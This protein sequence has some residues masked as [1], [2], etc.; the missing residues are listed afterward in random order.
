MTSTHPITDRRTGTRTGSHTGTRT[1]DTL[2]VCQAHATPCKGCDNAHPAYHHLH[3]VHPASRMACTAEQCSQGR[4]ACPTPQ[5][6]EVP[7][8][9][10]NEPATPLEII[11]FI[12][13]V[14]TAVAGAV[15]LVVLASGV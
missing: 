12:G 8:T 9:L 3:R 11:G 15:L 2:G 4:K 14:V 10:T 5:A 13:L 1:C 7:P 6:C